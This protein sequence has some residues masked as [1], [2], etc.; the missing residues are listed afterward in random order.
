MCLDLKENYSNMVYL[1]KS[2]IV[3]QSRT[4]LK[5]NSLG[6]HVIIGFLE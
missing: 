5:S 3:G 4:K 6:K 2:G 1:C